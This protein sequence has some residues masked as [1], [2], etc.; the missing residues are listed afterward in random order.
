M[1]IP[2]EKI[3]DYLVRANGLPNLQLLAGTP[4]VEKSDAWPWEWL[5]GPHFPTAQSREEYATRNDLDLLPSEPVG[6]LDFYEGRRLRMRERL[7]S[8]LGESAAST[9]V[10]GE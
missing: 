9:D 7:L 1:G 10:L 4:N 8:V 6:F 5:D 2:A 3:E